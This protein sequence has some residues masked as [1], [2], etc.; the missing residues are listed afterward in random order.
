M[1]VASFADDPTILTQTQPVDPM[2]L[3]A[4]GV[5]EEALR[6]SGVIPED[7]VIVDPS[8]AVETQLMALIDAVPME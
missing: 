7:T 3:Q 1:P 2:E 8:T 5:I 6:Q 4:L